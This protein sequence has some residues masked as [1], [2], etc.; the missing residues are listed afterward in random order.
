MLGRRQE[1][2]DPKQ[3][4][5]MAWTELCSRS[6]GASMGGNAGT[7]CFFGL[8]WLPRVAQAGPSLPSLFL[9]LPCA[10]IAGVCCR[11]QLISALPFCVICARDRMHAP[12]Q[13]SSRVVSL[14]YSLSLC[15][16]IKVG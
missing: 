1:Q 10:G 3:R 12:V 4:E 2:S 11:A 16:F 13:L 14:S 15:L 5:G 9:S 7:C 8:V 6:S